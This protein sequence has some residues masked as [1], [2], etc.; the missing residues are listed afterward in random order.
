[1]EDKT[2][3]LME[4]MY[5]EFTK[6]FQKVNEKLDQKADKTDIVRIENDHGEKLSALFDRYQ[7]NSDK[8]DCHTEML[9]RLDNRLG[10]V[11]KIVS[12]HS[13]KLDRLE[14]VSLKHTA[15]LERIDNK[16]ETHNTQIHV[17]DKTKANIK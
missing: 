16:L 17:L 11:E 4:K 6:E 7:Q 1:M 2:F 9:N 5:I 15:Q 13:D 10:G 14:K 8:L 12:S 3:E